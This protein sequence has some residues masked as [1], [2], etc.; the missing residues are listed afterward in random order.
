MV[1]ILQKTYFLHLILQ[2]NEIFEHIKKLRARNAF[3]DNA[4]LKDVVI[5]IEICNRDASKELGG[6]KKGTLKARVSITLPQAVDLAADKIRLKAVDNVVPGTID[7]KKL[8]K[9]RQQG[10][11][12]GKGLHMIHSGQATVIAP[13]CVMYHNQGK[14]RGK[15]G[16]YW[17][18]APLAMPPAPRDQYQDHVEAQPSKK[19]IFVINFSCWGA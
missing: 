19:G 2:V 14:G 4:Y 16:A 10:Y 6:A 1:S 17:G 9:E 15:G 13:N 18:N 11:P 12:R 7:K 3:L 8:L 5:P